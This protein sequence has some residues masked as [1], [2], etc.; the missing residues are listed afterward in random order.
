[1]LI[2]CPECQHEISDQSDACPQCGFSLAKKR[3]KEK[4]QANGIAFLALVLP[5][6]MMFVTCV[7]TYEPLPPEQEQALYEQALRENAEREAEWESVQSQ[8][9]AQ[10]ELYKLEYRLRK[11]YDR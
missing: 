11:Q 8:A 7:A 3:K 5:F 2:Q 6:L 9:E 1:M 10:K 4:G